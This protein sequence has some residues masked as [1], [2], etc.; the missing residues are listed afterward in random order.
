VNIPNSQRAAFANAHHANLFLRVHCDSGPSGMTGFLTLVPGRNKWTGP[1]V[2]ASA[3]AGK[4]V[5][6]AAVA[7]TGAN[8][9]GISQRTDL[10][11]FNW[12]KV[13]AVLVECGMMSNPGEDRKLASSS[14]QDKLAAGISAGVL[15][16]LHGN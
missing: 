16:Y 1:I 11:G 6:A 9:R 8:S 13:P 5:Q 10:S 4:D 15:R 12:S 7:A 3:R 14:Y 2:A